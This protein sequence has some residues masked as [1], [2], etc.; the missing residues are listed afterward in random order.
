MLE[1]RPALL[2]DILELDDP[3]RDEA[4]QRRRRLL[5]LQSEYLALATPVQLIDPAL[6]RGRRGR[7]GLPGGIGRA[8][9]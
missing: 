5:R 1:A 8:P 4:E 3:L 2:D 6:H 7:L 9:L